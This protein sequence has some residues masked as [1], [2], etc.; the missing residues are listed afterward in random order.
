VSLIIETLAV[1]P[2][3][4]NGFV[5]ACDGTRDAVL[6]DP[7]DEVDD[8]LRVVEARGLAV[9][10]ILITHG[11][12]DHVSGVARAKRATGARIGVHRDDVFLYNAAVQQGLAFGYRLEQPPPPDFDLASEGPLAL[13]ACKIEV[14][15]T[16]GHSPGGVCLAIGG[17]GAEEAHLFV[18]DTLFAGSIGRTDLPGGDYATLMRSIRNV[19]LAFGDGAIVHA[20]HGPDTTIGRERAT[21]PF[22]KPGG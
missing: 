14:H 20:G 7:G 16:P 6:I 15:H 8:L 12:M 3:Y 9:G 17:P 1:A 11:H 19:L 4:K 18:G 10:L 21:N 2:F 13:G 22:L 5:V